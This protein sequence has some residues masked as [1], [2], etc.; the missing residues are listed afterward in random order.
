[1][2]TIRKNVFETNS[3]STHSVVLRPNVLFD[4]CS[5]KRGK[6]DLLSCYENVP[7]CPE[8]KM[9]VLKRET[10]FSF[11][12]YYTFYEKLNYIVYLLLY[13]HAEELFTDKKD[14][15]WSDMR[16][17]VERG[18]AILDEHYHDF[19]KRIAEFA[20]KRYDI[21]CETIGFVPERGKGGDKCFFTFDH[22]VLY[23]SHEEDLGIHYDPFDLITTDGLAIHYEFC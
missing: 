16:F 10:D 2:R 5:R 7:Y 3:S 17:S 19:V 14:W 21:D 9:L 1:M 22:E 18:N 4:P 6:K 23:D 13:R 8:K 20:S 12:T 15:D 11:G